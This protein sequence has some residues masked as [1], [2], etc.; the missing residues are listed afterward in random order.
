MP[1]LTRFACPPAH[2]AVHMIASLSAH[3]QQCH[4]SSEASVDIRTT[5]SLPAHCHSHVLRGACWMPYLQPE[6]HASELT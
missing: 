2:H 1:M 5:T 3:E 6:F 4:L